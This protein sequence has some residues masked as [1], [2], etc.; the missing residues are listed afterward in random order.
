MEAA[1]HR[2]SAAELAAAMG[3]SLRAGYTQVS[4]MREGIKGWVEA[5]KKTV[6]FE[7]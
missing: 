1:R 7:G 5:G 3:V 6:A 2:H 4:V